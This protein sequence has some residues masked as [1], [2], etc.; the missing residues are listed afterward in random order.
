[1]LNTCGCNLDWFVLP[2]PNDVPATLG[3][4]QI[5]SVITIDVRIEFLL[6]PRPIGLGHDEMLGAAMPEAAID[7][8]G[9]SSSP[10][11]DICGRAELGL[12]A[13][14]YPKAQS[15]TV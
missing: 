4:R 3:E 8:N 14:V 2:D 5:G 7:E 12:G 11:Q 10:E 6:P 9:D 1:L 15:L 13:L